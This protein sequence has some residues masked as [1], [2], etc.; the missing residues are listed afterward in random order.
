MFGFTH[1]LGF[2]FTPRIRDPSGSKLFTIDKANEYPK[3]E[4][5]PVLSIST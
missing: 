2:N 1:L 5:G 3:L 4:G